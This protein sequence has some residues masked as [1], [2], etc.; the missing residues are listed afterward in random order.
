MTQPVWRASPG[1]ATRSCGRE[2]AVPIRTHPRVRMGTLACTS[3]LFGLECLGFC[4]NVPRPRG[5]RACPLLLSK[6]QASPD[7]GTE[8]GW[9]PQTV[10][11]CN[12][13]AV[14]G[15]GGVRAERAGGR[16]PDQGQSVD[17]GKVSASD[18]LS[19]LHRPHSLLS[20]VRVWG[21][22]QFTRVAWS[23]FLLTESSHV[24]MSIDDVCAVG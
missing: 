19:A 5:A 8:W 18:N 11:C 24:P 13:L 16:R 23:P 2:R 4:S 22:E 9:S 12:A 7:E 17:M 15:K 6:P 10:R 1:Q 3:R 21:G 20:S 14:G